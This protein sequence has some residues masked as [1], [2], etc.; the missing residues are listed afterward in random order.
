MKYVI[1]AIEEEEPLNM[2]VG[3]TDDI[4]IKND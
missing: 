1:L 3:A 4:C 2:S